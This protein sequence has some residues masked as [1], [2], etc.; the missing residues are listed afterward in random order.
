MIQS[1]RY[2]SVPEPG[3]YC[4]VWYSDIPQYNR[5]ND[6]MDETLQGEFRCDFRFDHAG[7]YIERESDAMLFQLKFGTGND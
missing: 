1:W 5:L 3:W 2:Q 4:R 7:V 6:W